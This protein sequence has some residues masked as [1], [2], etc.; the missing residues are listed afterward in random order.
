[1][2]AAPG[3]NTIHN[4]N[5]QWP[6]TTRASTMHKHSCPTMTRQPPTSS[7]QVANTL[8]LLSLIIF[9]VTGSVT[10]HLSASGS[11]NIARQATLIDIPQELC[12]GRSVQ[13]QESG[14][15]TLAPV[16]SKCLQEY[17][18]VTAN[19]TQGITLQ[20]LE[21]SRALIGN[22]HRLALLATKLQE[23]KDAVNAVVCGGSITI[24]HGVVP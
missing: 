18:R 10:W 11:N 15:Q 17:Q 19:R 8:Q 6:N 21:Q 12:Q 14:Q 22:R 24:G 16:R 13:E 1:M 23:R 2:H 5:G 9:F 20:D 4:C 3:Q 7:Q